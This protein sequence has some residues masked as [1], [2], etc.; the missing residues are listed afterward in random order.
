MR[1]LT[2]YFTDE[3]EAEVLDLP[4]DQKARVQNKARHVEKVGWEESLKLRLVKKLKNDKHETYEVIVKGRGPA[5]RLLCYP[6]A[7]RDGRLVLVAACKAK[8]ILLGRGLAR[9]SAKAAKRRDKWMSDHKE[10]LR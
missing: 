9:E 5:Y 8:R 3:A 10:E 2:I 1:K 4:A 6:L 7:G